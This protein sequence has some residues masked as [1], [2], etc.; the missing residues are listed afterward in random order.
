MS[1]QLSGLHLLLTYRCLLACEH[2]FVWGGPDQ[3]AVFTWPQLSQILDQA[4]ELGGITT[5]YLEGGEPF[6]YYPTMIRMALAAADRGY[7]VGVVTN[8]YW[9]TSHADALEWLRPLSGLL[10]DLSVSDDLFH[11]D[12]LQS[13]YARHAVSAAAELDIPV[14]TLVCSL[15][16]E[17][18]RPADRPAGEPL[19]RGPIM[20][21]GRAAALLADKAQ[22]QPWQNFDRCPHERLD[23]PFRVHIDP[24]GEIHL[25]QGLTMGNLYR[26]PLAELVHDYQPT[27]HPL[28]GPLLRGG[29]AALV[30]E[31]DLPVQTEYADACHLCYSARAMLRQRFAQFLGPSEMYGEVA[32]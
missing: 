14:A 6:L 18:S 2:C 29:P 31:Y 25:C 9:A 23:D 21:R 16:T 15:P 3:T 4:D 28:V 30:R 1:H 7:R 22:G 5:I 10:F 11:S 27:T 19:T 13:P 17:E 20:Y 32:A 24:Y 8:G 12:R 26:R